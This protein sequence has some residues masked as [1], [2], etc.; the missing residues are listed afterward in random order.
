MDGAPFVAEALR[1]GL[2]INCTHDHILRLLPAVHYHA[3]SDVAEFLA[4][5]EAVLARTREVRRR[6][7][8]QPPQRPKRMRSR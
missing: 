1:S 3:D 7:L 6:S 8:G 2:L 5:F 4:K